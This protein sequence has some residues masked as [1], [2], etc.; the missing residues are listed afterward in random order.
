M[1]T[2]PIRGAY[3]VNAPEQPGENRHPLRLL[4]GNGMRADV[5]T[6][7]LQRFG[8]V[9]VIEFYGSTEGNIV[10]ANL[11][12][13]LSPSQNRDGSKEAHQ[14]QRTAPV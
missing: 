11:S 5:W 14:E 3:L 1:S 13:L 10:L 9:Q 4:A 6:K 7:V 8:P 12:A 2:A